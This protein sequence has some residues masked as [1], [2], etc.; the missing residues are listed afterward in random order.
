MSAF[1]LL[2]LGKFAFY[3]GPYDLAFNDPEIQIYESE[4]EE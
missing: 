2:K 4:E 3:L 1:I